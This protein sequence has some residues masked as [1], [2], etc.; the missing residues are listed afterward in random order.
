MRGGAVSDSGKLEEA[1]ENCGA[2]EHLH[3]G[4]C[5]QCRQVLGR[6]VKTSEADRHEPR[7]APLV[8][9]H[10]PPWRRRGA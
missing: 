6:D 5:R 7:Q 9:F 2:I 3:D 10:R 8:P 1:C 4:L